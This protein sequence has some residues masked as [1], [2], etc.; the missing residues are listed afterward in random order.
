[1]YH[2]LLSVGVARYC[3]NENQTDECR[4]EHTQIFVAVSVNQMCLA[5]RCYQ[6]QLIHHLTMA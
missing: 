2:V 3:Q 5:Q 4:C 6:T 1:M